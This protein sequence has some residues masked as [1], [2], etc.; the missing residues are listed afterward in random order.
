MIWKTLITKLTRTKY[1]LIMAAFAGLGKTEFAAAFSN[2]GGL[3][4]ITA[5]NYDVNRFKDEL[6]KMYSLTDKSF[7]VNLTVVPPGIRFGDTNITNEDYLKY[8]EVAINKG[9]R[10]FTTSAFQATLLGNRIREAGCYWFHKC[11]LMRHAISAQKAGA[12]A[13]TLVGMEAA[14][15]KNPYQHTTLVN[16]TMAKKLLNIPVIAAGGIGDPRGFLGALIMGAEAVCL[17][18]AILTTME[19]PLSPEIKKNW[20]NVDIFDQNYHKSLYHLTLGPTRV[21]SSAIGF[22]KEIIPLKSFI[23]KLMKE[24]EEILKSNGFNKEE[25]NTIF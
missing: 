19:S 11:A 8:L 22:Q 15:F 23:E 1:P 24:A 4:V 12:N 20:M 6:D 17:G 5:F 18:T 14:G 16:L 13:V 25:F 10:I 21:P 2:S 9:V 3:G 7:G